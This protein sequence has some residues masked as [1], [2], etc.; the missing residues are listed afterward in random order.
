[1][2]RGTRISSGIFLLLLVVF[3]LTRD[4]RVSVGV[5][6]LELPEIG[7]EDV[8]GIELSG[9]FQLR[10]LK[11]AD[12]WTVRDPLSPERNFPVDASAIERALGAIAEF[13]A[14][15][16]VSGRPEKHAELELDEELGTTVTISREGGSAL[17]LVLGRVAKNG[18][19]FVRL[20]DSDDVFVAS[21]ALASSLKRE[22]NDWRRR[23]LL[24]A[25]PEEIAKLTIGVPGGE[26]ELEIVSQPGPDGEAGGWALA[27]ETQLPE[28]FVVD[29]AA[30]AARVRAFASLRALDFVDVD[31]GDSVTGLGEGATRVS[32]RTTGGEE[33][34]VRFGQPDDSGRVHARRDPDPQIYLVPASVANQFG[35]TLDSLRDLS[36]FRFDANAVRQFSIR[37]PSGSVT[38]ERPEEAP[39][40]RLEEPASPPADYE[41]SSDAVI[42]QL[43]SLTRTR[44]T[45]FLGRTDEVG[46]ALSRIV[47]LEFRLA[48]GNSVRVELGAADGG[49]DRARPGDGFSYTLSGGLRSRFETPLDLFRKVEALPGAGGLG[50]MGGAQGL[51]NLPPDLRRRIEEAMRNQQGGA[52]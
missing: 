41:F 12:T 32:A 1:M 34:A 29:G 3:L 45:R 18:G 51:E 27:P 17:T 16:F 20:R 46:A 33:I 5:R 39:I 19:T 2:S 6:R 52:P 42:S 11:D 49:D 47:E 37:H 35:E 24:S 30:L 44:A 50:N 9:A 23:A 15:A 28:G 31:P 48:D 25:E 4:D 22:L 10:L 7:A 21:G 40:W 13:E 36:L 8:A 26:S 43:Q 14:G 38:M